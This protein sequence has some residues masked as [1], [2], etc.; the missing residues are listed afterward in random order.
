MVGK[1]T[2]N[3][4]DENGLIGTVEATDVSTP[5]V[6]ADA[7]MRLTDGRTVSGVAARVVSADDVCARGLALVSDD[8]DAPVSVLS[9][10][11]AEQK[12][13]PEADD[14]M[15]QFEDFDEQDW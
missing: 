10:S 6:G 13:R 12:P 8:A 14:D 5:A 3:I 11:A 7:T 2:V 9:L 15:K 1:R 4:V